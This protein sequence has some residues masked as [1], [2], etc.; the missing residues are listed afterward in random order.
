VSKIRKTIQTLEEARRTIQK[1]EL[2]IERR[3]PGYGTSF[4]NNPV[5]GKIFTRTD[6]KITYQYYN[7]TWNDISTG[8]GGGTPSTNYFLFMDG[9]RAEMMDSTDLELMAS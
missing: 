1:L 4:P 9:T 8:S 5:N 7:S 6:Q 2:Y 3:L